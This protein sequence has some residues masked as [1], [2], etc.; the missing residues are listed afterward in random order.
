MTVLQQTVPVPDCV[1]AEQPAY[2]EVGGASLYTVLHEVQQPVARVLLVGP[3]AF[4]R[5]T[6]YRTWVQWARY[7]AARN[8][9]VL[10][11]DYRGVGESTGSFEEM[12]FPLWVDDV[13]QLCSW[14]GKRAGHAPLLLHGLELGAIL[15]AKIFERGEG[16]GLLLW[17]A[18]ENANKVLRSS[19][20]RWI[21]PQQLLKH[22]DE[23]TPPSHYFGLL[24]RGDSVEI[25]G[26]EWSPELWRQSM[27]FE[28]PAALTDSEE[29]TD[30][31]KRPVHI[32]AL[33]RSAAPL[34][35]SGMPGYEENKDFTWLFAPNYEWIVS[36]LGTKGQRS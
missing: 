14:L 22:K 24:D 9:E 28:L 18:P 11:Y 20:T 32:A 36:S 4:E 30:V 19:L 10:R 7:L 13:Q 29:A 17:A 31:Y 34:I 12:T 3:F 35:K 33:G 21:S 15:A 8:I 23:R 16:D 6:S 27:T 26:W 5:H 2:F 1:F 25:E